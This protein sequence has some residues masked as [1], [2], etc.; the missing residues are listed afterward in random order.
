MNAMNDHIGK[1]KRAYAASGGTH[2]DHIDAFTNY[3]ESRLDIQEQQEKEMI[4]E[5]IHRQL[6]GTKA[7][8]EVDKVSLQNAKKAIMDLFSYF[9]SKR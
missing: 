1:I 5:E 2:A 7:A 9:N 4:A 6:S 3:V 8:V